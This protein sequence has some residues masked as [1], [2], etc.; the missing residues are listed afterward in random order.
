MCG[1]ASC[2]ATKDYCND[3]RNQAPDGRLIWPGTTPVQLAKY[4][5]AKASGKIPADPAYRAHVRACLTWR[6]KQGSREFSDAELRDRSVKVYK[7]ERYVGAAPDRS[8][9]A[10]T[11]L[12]I[13]Q[14]VRMFEQLNHLK[15][16]Q[17]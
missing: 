8:F 1:C 2:Q 10:S 9:P 3:D 6:P 5:R 11:V 17:P 4:Q 7:A 15:P 16:T 14:Y 12:D 13:R